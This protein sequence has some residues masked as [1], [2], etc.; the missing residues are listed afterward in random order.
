MNGNEAEREYTVQNTVYVVSQYLC[1]REI[2]RREVQYLNLGGVD[3]TR[4][5][6]S[7]FELIDNLF[8]MDSFD[9]VFRVFRGEQRA[10][11]EMMIKSSYGR[12][13][14]MGY[15]E[16]VNCQDESF[17]RWL[18]KLE[19]DVEILSKEL[20]KRFDRLFNLQHSLIDLIDYLDPDFIIFQDESRKKA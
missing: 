2:I 8:L 9:R 1:W 10:I 20:P 17:R 14:C 7:L 15:A 4:K 3:A 13:F 5:L 6:S 16:F 12:L 18:N 11:G 19:N